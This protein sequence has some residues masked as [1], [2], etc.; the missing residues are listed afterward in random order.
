MGKLLVIASVVISLATAGIGFVN[1]GQL[2]ETKDSLTAAE[3]AKQAADQ[4]VAESGKALKAKTD[5]LATATA[6]KEQAV[7]AAAQAKSDLDKANASL[8]DATGKATAAEGKVADLEAQLTTAKEQIASAANASQPVSTEPNAET[9]ALIQEQQTLI[10][11]LQ[12]ELD[13][14]KAVTKDLETKNKQRELKVLAKGTEGRVLAVNPA[15]NFVVLNLGD[16]QGVANNTELLVKRGTR[17]LGKV[18]ITSVEPSTSIADIVANSMPQGTT[19]SPGDNV[20]FQG[21]EE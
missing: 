2:S 14:T 19:I 21:S 8:A 15:W 1:K 7:A 4:K 6:E 11:K 16:K 18:R 5:E 17:Y 20:I 3:S 10:A 12:Q 13:S 9:Q